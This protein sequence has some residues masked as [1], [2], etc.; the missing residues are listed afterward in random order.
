MYLSLSAIMCTVFFINLFSL[1][2][3][4]DFY[5]FTNRHVSVPLF[6]YVDIAFSPVY[7]CWML[8]LFQ[9]SIEA[10]KKPR[11]EYSL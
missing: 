3:P 10:W 4:V 2:P 1:W 11:L 7:R 9:G 8:L 5:L 6:I